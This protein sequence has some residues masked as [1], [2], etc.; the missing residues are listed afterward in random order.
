MS[1]AQM[2]AILKEKY[3]GSTKFDNMGDNQIRV[4][5]T[6]LLNEGKLKGYTG[7]GY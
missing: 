6:R 2:R 4:I 1:I 7:R 5:Y 3:N